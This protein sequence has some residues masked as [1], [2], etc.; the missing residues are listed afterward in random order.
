MSVTVFV[1]CAGDTDSVT[2]NTKSDG[3]TMVSETVTDNVDANGYLLDTLPADLDFG[4]KTVN[5][6]VRSA[7]AATEFYV[8][9]MSGDI[10]DDA[11]YMRNRSVEERLNVKVNF[12]EMPGEWNERE[13]MNGA[14]RASVMANDGAYDIAAVLSNQLSIL[15]LE[16][17]L[18]NLSEMNYLDFSK[19]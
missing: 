13:T 8:P 15:T 3:D 1:S 18:T 17:L 9:E 4:G 19:P 5:V 2:A 11:M 7:V 10:V 12:I 14:I 16:G 6:V